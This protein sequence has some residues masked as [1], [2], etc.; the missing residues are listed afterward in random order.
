MCA[1]RLRLVGGQ[2]VKL[3]CLEAVCGRSRYAVVV[4]DEVVFAVVQYVE[5]PDA[6]EF[7]AAILAHYHLTEFVHLAFYA[8]QGFGIAQVVAVDIVLRQYR[9]VHGESGI[10]SDSSCRRQ[11]YVVLL[12]V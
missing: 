8:L 6:A 10:E 4:R 5:P 11:E 3:E 12:I 1:C 9:I 7:V 2:G